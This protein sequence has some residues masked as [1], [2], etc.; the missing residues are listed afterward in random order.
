LVPTYLRRFPGRQAGGDGNHY[1]ALDGAD[2]QRLQV[3]V[4]EI[5]RPLCVESRA[6]VILTDTI[7]GKGLEEQADNEVGR[8]VPLT[9]A[10][11]EYFVDVWWRWICVWPAMGSPRLRCIGGQ[12][13]QPGLPIGLVLENPTFRTYLDLL[14]R[15]AECSDAARIAAEQAALAAPVSRWST[16]STIHRRVAGGVCWHS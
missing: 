9:A 8:I 1:A 13:Q 10:G 4:G 7:A 14:G 16:R 3:V 12:D 2:L 11:L 5:L 6:C 15:D